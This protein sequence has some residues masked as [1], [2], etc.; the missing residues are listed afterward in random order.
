MNKK[1]GLKSGCTWV[2]Q[3]G[4]IKDIK[5]CWHNV[6]TIKNICVSKTPDYDDEFTYEIEA[7]FM[8]ESSVTLTEPHGN[9]I[10]AQYEL[11]I[12][13]EYIAGYIRND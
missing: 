1:E 8:D 7:T 2:G 5:H 10:L 12:I 6:K 11:D 4:F 9:C 3:H 13:L